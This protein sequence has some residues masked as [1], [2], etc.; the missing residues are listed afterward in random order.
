MWQQKQASYAS[1]H[2]RLGLD[3]ERAATEGEAELIGGARQI[4]R[5]QGAQATCPPACPPSA[6]S[7][8][9]P[10]RAMCLPVKVEQLLDE[11]RKLAREA[12]AVVLSHP[13]RG[14]VERLTVWF[15]STHRH[16]T[17]GAR[18]EPST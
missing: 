2:A 3:K 1:A 13:T 4:V 7:P 5:Q 12:D 17:S 18:A 8:Q 6:A 11:Q 14:R 9:P 10:Q 15:L 16:S